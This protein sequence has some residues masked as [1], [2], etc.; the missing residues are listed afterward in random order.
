MLETDGMAWDEHVAYEIETMCWAR[1]LLE[2][3]WEGL[4]GA[5]P[6]GFE[7]GVLYFEALLMHARN[8]AEFFCKEPTHPDTLRPT[9]CGLAAYDYGQPK[10]RFEA[11]IGEPFDDVYKRICTYVSHLSTK[12]D[13]GVPN[14]FPDDLVNA[15]VAEATQ[16]A[17]LVDA[18][19]GNSARVRDAIDHASL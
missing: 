9:D 19:G 10:V 2:G 11:A 12:R 3:K 4:Q 14:W 15:L 16:F 13:L 5:T 7:E 6:Q 8:L 17:G 18:A 1:G